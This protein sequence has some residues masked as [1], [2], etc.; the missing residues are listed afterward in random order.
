[1][2]ILVHF[3]GVPVELETNGFSGRIDIDQLTSID[4]GNLYGEAVTVSALL[5]KVG[6]LRAEAEQAL[7]EKKLERDVCEADTK[8][9][10]RQQANANQGKFCFEGE[11]IKLSERHWMRRCY[12]M[13][14]IRDCAVSILRHKR[15][16]MSLTLCNGRYKISLR[17][18]II[19]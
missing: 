3:S 19:C 1:M 15:T 10:W 8:R 13:M 7:A 16:L 17:N 4:Y 18:L 5:N 14:L 11:W 12:L 9:K 2:K 6:L